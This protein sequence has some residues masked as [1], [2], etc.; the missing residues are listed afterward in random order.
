MEQKRLNESQN[1][2]QVSKS[3]QKVSFSSFTYFKA[4]HT[5]GLNVN[6]MLGK[7]WDR[8]GTSRGRNRTYAPVHFPYRSHHKATE[9]VASGGRVYLS[10]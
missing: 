6:G 5:Y 3:K 10:E 1:G 8:I 9:C 4:R 7:L 2:T